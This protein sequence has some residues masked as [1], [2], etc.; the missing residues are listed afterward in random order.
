MTKFE[1]R[2]NFAIPESMHSPSCDI[3]TDLAT[4]LVLQKNKTLHFTNPNLPADQ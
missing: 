3:L 4:V 1:S 2:T